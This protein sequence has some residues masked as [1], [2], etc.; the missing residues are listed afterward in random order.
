MKHYADMTAAIRAQEEDSR[1]TANES[2]LDDMLD[3][4]KQII[5]AEGAPDMDLA[6]AITNRM[7]TLDI[8]NNWDYAVD[9]MRNWAGFDNILDDD[10]YMSGM[11]QGDYSRVSRETAMHE[12]AH[13]IVDLETGNGLHKIQVGYDDE[14]A[15]I[16]S[17]GLTWAER[18]A[19][20]KAVFASMIAGRQIDDAFG[21]PS[22][23][24]RGDYKIILGNMA[25]YLQE[26]GETYDL[27][28][29]NRVIGEARDDAREI[30][31]N[32]VD[33]VIALADA[34]M[35]KGHIDGAAAKA[36]ALRNGVKVKVPAPFIPPRPIK[37]KPPLPPRPGSD[38]KIPR[39]DLPPRPAGHRTTVDSTH[40]SLRRVPLPPRTPENPSKTAKTPAPNGGQ[41]KDV[42]LPPSPRIKIESNT[43]PLAPP[44]PPHVGTAGSIKAPQPVSRT[45]SRL[46]IDGKTVLEDKVTNFARRRRS[47]MEDLLS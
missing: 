17:L 29:Q 23:S 20:Y 14:S 6:A 33:A 7:R 10:A 44:M 16:Q 19:S 38:G 26:K 27:K 12:A 21:V 43:V 36:I 37:V 45:T 9:R 3:T 25:P 5:E 24:A 18:D 42:P 41:V 35:K 4:Q 39:P 31:S 2:R 22:T 1:R 34:L 47:T 40:G 30:L 32:R 13:A 8:D 28:S 46:K 11:N 15:G